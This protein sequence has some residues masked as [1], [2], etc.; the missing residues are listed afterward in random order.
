MHTCRSEYKRERKY[1]GEE[2]QRGDSEILVFERGI[3]RAE[4]SEQLP[5][6][7]RE[8]LEVGNEEVGIEFDTS[9]R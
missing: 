5:N 2:L 1:V 6:G 9:R 7:G 3:S 4:G 8:G